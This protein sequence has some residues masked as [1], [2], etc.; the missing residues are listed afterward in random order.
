MK[1]FVFLMILCVLTVS[2]TAQSSRRP[3]NP[4]MSEGG[5]MMGGNRMGGGGR[6]SGPFKDSLLHRTGLEDSATITYRYLDTSRFSFLDSSVN[7]YSRRWYIP[8]TSVFLGNT[9]NASRSLL[10]NPILKSGW[11]HGMHAYDAYTMQMSDVKFY[12]TTRPY[13]QLVYVLGSKA[14]Q[15]IS[16]FH[17]Q[18]IRYNWNFS[19]N[20]RLIN[21]P[22]FFKNQKTNHNNYVFNTW[23]VAPKRRYNVFFVALSNKIGG[24]ENGGIKSMNYLDSVPSFS[25]RFNIPTNFGGSAYEGSSFLSNTIYTGNKYQSISLLLRQQYDFGKK[26]SVTT[27]SSVAYFYYPRVRLQHTVQYNRYSFQYFDSRIDTGAYRQFYQ[28]VPAKDTLSVKDKW[29]VLDNEFAIYQFPDI[30]NQ[31]QFLKLAAGIQ[32]LKGDFG[33]KSVTYNTIYLNGEYRNKTRNKKWDMELAG[34]FYATGSYAGDYH[35]TAYLKRMIGAKLGYLTLGFQNANRTPSFVNNDLS[36]FRQFNTAATNFGKENTTVFSALYELPQQKLAVGAKYFLASNYVYFKSYTSS[37]QEATLFNVLQLQVQK[38]F[39][40]SR[41]WNWYLEAYLQQSTG[42]APV[43]LPL[44]LARSRIAYEGRFFKNLNMSTGVE[45][46]YYTPYKADGYSPLLGQF[47]LQQQETINNLPDITAYIHF[48]IRS[49]YLFVRAENLNTVQVSPAFGF[50]N[51]NLAAP[52]QPL[53]GM[54]IR[55]GIY[56]GFVN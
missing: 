40:L 44:L 10:F 50:L 32:S 30:K 5:G 47:F 52:L 33:V 45:A 24:S 31:Q 34:T 1:R 35:V 49:L 43:N 20:Y 7:D 48:R 28:F 42:A 22:G 37:A 23:Y 13:S 11:D 29:Q 27:D 26:D 54:L 2:V 19:F 53:P 39:K 4:L 6:S 18:N 56:W 14:E 15:N 9:G 36:N 55:F 51:N 17:T 41:R 21:S 8:W 12:N 16:V 3:G 38:Q 25:T 46:R